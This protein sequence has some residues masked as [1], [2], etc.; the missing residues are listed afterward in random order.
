MSLLEIHAA[1]TKRLLD[2]LLKI[3]AGAVFIIG[4]IALITGDFVVFPFCVI[5]LVSDVVA[6]FLTN[7]VKVPWGYHIMITSH[8]LVFSAVLWYRPEAYSA[9]ISFPFLIPLSIFFFKEKKYHIFYGVLATLGC[10]G[11][12]LAITQNDARVETVGNY[13]VLNLTTIS[14]LYALYAVCRHYIM[15]LRKYQA[16]LAAKELEMR[17]QNAELESYIASNL[18]LENFAHLASHELRS[19]LRNIVN[20]SDLL[21]H[22]L[23]DSLSSE[24]AEAL[25]IVSSQAASLNESVG[26]LLQ[27]AMVSKEPIDFVSIES[28]SILQDVIA[29]HFAGDRD[30]IQLVSLPAKFR[31]HP[32]QMEH[33]FRNILENA[34]KFVVEGETP[35]ISIGGE[36]EEEAVS[37]W[38]RDNGI[39]IDEAHKDQAFVIFKRLHSEQDFAGTG[40]GLAICK[41]IVDRH[42]GRIWIEN[43]EAGGTTVHFRIPQGQ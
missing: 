25:E 37:F 8:I 5:L 36:E 35:K 20:F 27:L 33:L 18:Q 16:N 26:D 13:L 15:T 14:I 7:R 3:A 31:G 23:K 1:R 12:I 2:V 6:I 22:R 41:K 40:I 24:D 17:A 9:L 10:M 38:V 43:N 29:K 30:H 28:Q 34:L 32:G 4:T 21:K 11:G 42:N 19:P 39:G